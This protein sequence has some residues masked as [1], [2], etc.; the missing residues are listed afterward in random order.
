MFPRFLLIICMLILI[1]CDDKT[2]VVEPD[3]NQPPVIDRVILP[4]QIE[5]NTPI[6]LQVIAHDTDQDHLSIT[7]E[8]SEGTVG[9]DIWTPPDRAAEVTISVHV[10]DGTNPTVIQSKNVTVTKQETVDSSTLTELQPQPEPPPPQPSSQPEPEPPQPL[11]EP[12]PPPPRPEPE[13]PPREPEGPQTWNIIPRVGIEYIAPGQEILTIFIGGTREQV[14]ALAERSEWVDHETQILFHPQL[15]EIRCFYREGKV[16][17]ITV[18]HPRYKPQEDV[19]VGMHIDAAITKYGA[20]D[21]VNQGEKFA[22]YLYYAHGYLFTVTRGKRIASTTIAIEVE[23]LPPAFEVWNIIPRVGIEYI[24]PGQEPLKVSFGDTNEQVN[25]LANTAKWIG[26]DTGQELSHPRLGRFRCY[27]KEGKVYQIV[28]LDDRFKT[29]ERIGIGSSKFAVVEAYGEPDE[30]RDWKE[31]TLYFY[32][33][34]NCVFGFPPNRT[35][36]SFIAFE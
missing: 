34:L 1:G 13:P 9:G 14:T 20:P 22:A 6:K 31:F 15:G 7:W 5:A 23:S 28:V 8:V 30:I 25:A 27:Y 32:E 11:P 35:T 12:E 36:V 10:T 19:R 3:S 29:E 2:D 21:K 24:A 26:D 18:N 4:N 16:A 17:A 33:R